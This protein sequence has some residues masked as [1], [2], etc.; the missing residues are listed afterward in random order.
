MKKC[1]LLFVLL[2][3]F[4]CQTAM[5]DFYK[6][7]DEK[8]E[9][10]ITDFPPPQDKV[11][12]DVEIHKSPTVDLTNKENADDSAKKKI[13][14]VLYTKND[15]ADCDKARE[16]LKSKNIAF[17]EYNMDYDKEAAAKR[18]EVDDGDDVPFAVINKSRVFGFKESVYDKAL[19]V[20]P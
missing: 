16:Y 15:C 7:V 20:E 13:N 12:K 3:F 1:L 17:T 6:W 18:K 4:L 5:A 11:A 19:K 8:G 2:S 14:V 9:T 10:Q